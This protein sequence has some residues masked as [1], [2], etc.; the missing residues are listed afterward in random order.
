L[1]RALPRRLTTAKV[2]RRSVDK[3]RVPIGPVA[4]TT[5]ATWGSRATRSS[6]SANAARTSG[7]LA[8]APAGRW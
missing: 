8:S 7:A 5:R 2:L 4:P 3:K 1:A 6:V